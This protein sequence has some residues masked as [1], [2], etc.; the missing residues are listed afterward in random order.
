MVFKRLSKNLGDIINEFDK[1]KPMKIIL[2]AL[3]Y[4]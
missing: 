4:G 2:D 3:D 1:N